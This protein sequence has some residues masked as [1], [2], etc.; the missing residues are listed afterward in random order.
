MRSVHYNLWIPSAYLYN[1]NHIHGTGCFEDGYP[2]KG[3][4]LQWSNSYEHISSDV[5]GIVPVAI[6]E[7]SDGSVIEVLSKN[8]RFDIPSIC[9][10][11]K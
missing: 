10:I 11:N 3:I 4:F 6:V 2:N 9:A 5:M 7:L 1:G 8:I